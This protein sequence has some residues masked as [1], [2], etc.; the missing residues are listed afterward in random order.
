MGKSNYAATDFSKF[1]SLFAQ[2]VD[3]EIKDTP[4]QGIPV[5]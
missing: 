2:G 4:P 3:Y 1:F 5:T